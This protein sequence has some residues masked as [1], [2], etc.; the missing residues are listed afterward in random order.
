VIGSS[1]W[2]TR[3]VE[4]NATVVLEAPRLKIRAESDD[5]QPDANFQI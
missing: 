4:P 1:V 2:L 3:S 5:L